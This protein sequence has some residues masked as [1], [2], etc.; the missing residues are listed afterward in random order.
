MK[1]SRGGS[2]LAFPRL[3]MW[4]RSTCS[5]G[6]ISTAGGTHVYYQPSRRRI[7]VDERLSANQQGSRPL[8]KLAHAHVRHDRQADDPPLN[9]LAKSSSPGRARRVL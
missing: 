6:A 3:G 5:A 7:A 2:V 1:S 8:P 9:K 4:R